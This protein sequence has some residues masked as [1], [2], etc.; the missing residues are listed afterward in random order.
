MIR[1][2]LARLRPRR[3]SELEKWIEHQVQDF[4]DRLRRGDYQ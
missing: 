3:K 1:R 4:E 2:F